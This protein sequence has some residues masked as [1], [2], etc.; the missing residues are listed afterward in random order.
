M[1]LNNK[2][3]SQSRALTLNNLIDINEWQKIHDNFIAI[4]GTC[5]R[6]VDLEGK[7][8]TACDKEPRLCSE[9]FK[10]H[11]MKEELCGYCLPTFLGGKGVVDKNMKMTCAAGLC[12]FLAPI[13]IDEGSVL[14]YIVLGPLILVMRKPKEEY[15]SLAEEL[16]IDLEVFWDALVEIKVVSIGG[17]Q[18]IIELAKDITE[19]TIKLAYQNL[20]M[21]K[22]GKEKSMVLESPK[23]SKILEALLDVAFQATGADIGSIMFFDK[24]KKDEMTIRASRGLPEEV[25][26]K[27]RVRLG[28]GIAGIAA[29]ENTSFLID[30]NLSDNRI[31]SYLNRPYISSSMVIPIEVQDRVIGVMNLGTLKSSTA[32]FDAN[33]LQLMDKLL[34]LATVALH[35]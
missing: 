10:S 2:N 35:E 25:V 18:S 26:S 14:G 16:G 12:N 22:K 17:A 30:D 34:D 28:D 21:Q 19:Y 24:K 9:I 20:T 33:N 27:A 32:R 6:L 3:D 1:Q 15:R 29:K 31:K 5:I 13:R 23:I 11:H 8:I 7:D 4:T